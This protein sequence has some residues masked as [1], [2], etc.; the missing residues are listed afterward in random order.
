MFLLL[1]IWAASHTRLTG[2]A[3]RVHCVRI[4]TH[5]PCYEPACW[6]LNFMHFQTSVI[7]LVDRL[8]WFYRFGI[9]LQI[10]LSPKVCDLSVMFW[11]NIYKLGSKKYPLKSRNFGN[12]VCLH[13]GY[14]GKLYSIY[15]LLMRY[16]I[17]FSIVHSAIFDIVFQ[18][19]LGQFF[20]KSSEN[21]GLFSPF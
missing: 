11:I 6:S 4:F 3:G 9:T 16:R 13:L 17:W 15:L 2:T 12:L 18:M 20:A 10:N 7:R 8:T 19:S 21:L 1:K 14:H 5:F